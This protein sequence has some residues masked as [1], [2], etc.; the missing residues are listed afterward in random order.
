M[1]KAGVQKRKNLESA[2]DQFLHS[3]HEQ[4]KPFLYWE[5]Q[6]YIIQLRNQAIQKKYLQTNQFQKK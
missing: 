3:L 2:V 5:H 4:G 1:E 6:D